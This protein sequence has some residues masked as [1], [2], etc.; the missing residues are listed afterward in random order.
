MTRH[1]PRPGTFMTSLSCH[2][3]GQLVPAFGP[4]SELVQVL[5][6]ELLRSIYVDFDALLERCAG[7]GPTLG[8]LRGCV[9]YYARSKELAYVIK[10]LKVKRDGFLAERNSELIGSVAALQHPPLAPNRKT[11]F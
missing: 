8:D 5:Y 7:R 3:M 2:M 10:G 4:Y 1:L 9:T 6:G 11:R